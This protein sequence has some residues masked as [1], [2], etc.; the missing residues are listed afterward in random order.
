MKILRALLWCLAIS[1]VALVFIWLLSAS[2]NHSLWR[3]ESPDTTAL[4]DTFLFAG[5]LLVTIAIF[6]E[7]IIARWFGRVG[8][9]LA[10]Q[11]EWRDDEAL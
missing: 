9:R 10:R 7:P 1:F 3:T 2:A 8:P 6:L 5:A 11:K 4:A